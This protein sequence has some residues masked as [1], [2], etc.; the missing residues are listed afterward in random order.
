MLSC[1]KDV[2]LDYWGLVVNVIPVHSGPLQGFDLCWEGFSLC[3]QISK[4]LL[5]VLIKAIKDLRWMKT[6][7]VGYLDMPS[8]KHRCVLSEC[9][10]EL[11]ETLA[12]AALSL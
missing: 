7:L 6:T 2:I 3:F 1:D 12:L 4:V 8:A 11:S 10:C 5:V 9:W